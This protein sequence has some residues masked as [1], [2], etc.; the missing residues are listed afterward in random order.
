M[1]C[2]DILVHQ[3]RQRRIHFLH[4]L[5]VGATSLIDEAKSPCRKSCQKR[6]AI[7]GAIIHQIGGNT[8]RQVLWWLCI[9]NDAD[10]REGNEEEKRSFHN[11]TMT[12]FVISKLR[13]G[14]RQ[15]NHFAAVLEKTSAALFGMIPAFAQSAEVSNNGTR[16]RHISLEV[17]TTSCRYERSCSLC[18]QLLPRS[19]RVVDATI[20]SFNLPASVSLCMPHCSRTA[21]KYGSSAR[22]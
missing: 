12:V 2:H 21:Y 10:E 3:D 8:P 4:Q 11:G 18:I 15:S 5:D 1:K 14:P 6:I 9:H 17:F 7:D 22:Q 19:P 20:P 16:S 13:I